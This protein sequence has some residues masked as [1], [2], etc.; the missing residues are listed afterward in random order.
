MTEP[1]WESAFFSH[2]GAV[3]PVNEDAF[4]EAP[5]IGLWAVADGMGG[6]Q[7]GQTASRMVVDALDALAPGATAGG[8][9]DGVRRELGAVNERLRTLA[10]EAFG[11]QTVGSTVAVL[12]LSGDA[13]ICL[14]AGDSRIYRLRDGRLRQLTL[15]HSRI[16]EMIQG[17]LVDREQAASHPLANI[18]TRAVG[19][20]DELH[21]DQS[22]DDARG[23]DRFLL[24]TD[25]LIRTMTDAEIEAI[26][27]RDAVADAARHLLEL[28]LTRRPADNVTLGLVEIAGDDDPTEPVGRPAAR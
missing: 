10:R 27:G 25:G 2:P 8:L 15:D 26:L 23:G 12:I 22:H 7:A 11:G 28:A 19:G 20:D 18:I 24:C 17:G 16:E 9:E 21:L 1:S 3:R 4:L 13:A 14:W 5:D 6:H